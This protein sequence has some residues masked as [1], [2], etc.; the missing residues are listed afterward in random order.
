[1]LFLFCSAAPVFLGPESRGNALLFCVPFVGILF[2]F[3]W[4]KLMHGRCMFGSIIWYAAS[5]INRIFL[6]PSLKKW[7]NGSYMLICLLHGWA[8]TE[9]WDVKKLCSVLI[10]LWIIHICVTIISF[11]FAELKVRHNKNHYEYN[12]TL[13]T[14]L[15]EYASAVSS[16]GILHV[17]P[18]HGIR[19]IWE[20]YVF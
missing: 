3:Y 5:T 19:I 17:E 1:M 12:H 16:M 2:Y 4:W 14:I 18:Y 7:M 15:V 13:A 9:S 10:V 11:P 6:Y 20:L 8:N